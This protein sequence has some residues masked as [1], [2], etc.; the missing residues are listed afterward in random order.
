VNDA[1]LAEKF[2][3]LTALLQTQ[4]GWWRPRAFVQRQLPWEVANPD[5][6]QHLRALPLPESERL[7]ADETALAQFLAPWIPIAAHLPDICALPCA[8]QQRSI[9]ASYREPVGVPGR[10]WQQIQA[11]VG[12]LAS[13]QIPAV[14][15]C[16]GKAHLGR[17]YAHCGSADVDA[18][19]WSAE[20]VAAGNQLSEREHLPVRVHQVDVLSPP[21]G[22]YLHADRQVLALHACGQLHV[23]LLQLCTSAHP[24]QRI[25]LAPCCYH[26]NP[27]ALYQPMSKAARAVDMPLS[28][29][30]LHTAVQE[31]V[32]SPERVQKQRRQLQAWRLG[33]DQLQRDA[34]GIDEYLST[35]SQA[36]SVLSAGFAAYCE[37]MAEL[38]NI[39]LPQQV[40][41]SRYEQLGAQ[42]FAE[43]SA[44]DLPRVLFR[45]ALELWLVLDRALLLHE[46]GYRVDVSIFCERVLTPRNVLITAQRQ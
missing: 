34:R 21:A 39:A 4:Q 12:G 30:D 23:H 32:T 10:K 9:S 17:W 44:L 16:A 29:L 20:L 25:A 27:H 38:K 41:Y 22:N 7:A 46:N 31:S 42:R 11:F 14:E 28:K 26:L 2:Q 3:M 6:S 18:L 13:T 35:P 43:V 24:V 37:R 36:L 15:W 8:P 45:R 33:F 1:Q 40:D 5:L 19:E